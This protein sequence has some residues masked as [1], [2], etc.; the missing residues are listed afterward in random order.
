[1][2]RKSYILLGL[3]VLLCIG[4][5][6]AEK[7]HPVNAPTQSIKEVQQKKENPQNPKKGKP[8]IQTSAR[9]ENTVYKPVVE[10]AKAGPQKKAPAQTAVKQ[11]KKNNTTKVS[12]KPT[13]AVAKNKNKRPNSTNKKN[14]N[15]KNTKSASKAT[16]RYIALKANVP[17]LAVVTNINNVPI[18]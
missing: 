11:T 18:I 4:E 10:K 17:F 5:A 7:P 3:A 9:P 1:M 6:C 8:R 13:K 14:T 15:K 16:N 12:P 2:N